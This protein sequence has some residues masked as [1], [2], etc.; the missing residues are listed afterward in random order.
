M[1]GLRAVE[2]SEL[3]EK[4]YTVAYY[5]KLKNTELQTMH[6]FVEKATK[7]LKGGCQ[8]SGICRRGQSKC[9]CHGR[10][11]ERSFGGKGICS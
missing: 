7:L 6:G 1:G 8:T 5:M 2:V 11:T 9:C 3:W 10:I 4:I